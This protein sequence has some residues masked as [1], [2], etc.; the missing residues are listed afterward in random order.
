MGDKNAMLLRLW[1]GNVKL[2]HFVLTF[3]EPLHVFETVVLRGFGVRQS[4]IQLALL[5]SW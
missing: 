5:A 2:T 3:Q 1:T 4:L